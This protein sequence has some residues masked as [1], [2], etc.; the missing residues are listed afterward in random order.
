LVERVLLE[1]FCGGFA[2]WPLVSAVGGELGGFGD[3][4]LVFEQGSRLEL[5]RLALDDWV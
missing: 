4:E 3:D 5:G 1:G 2:G